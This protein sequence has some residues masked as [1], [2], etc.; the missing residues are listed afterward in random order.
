VEELGFVGA[1]FLI[2]V[3]LFLIVKAITITKEA[4][5]AEGRILATGIA[6][7]IAIQSLF[8]IASNVAL[9][10]LTG[11]PLPFISH[12]G[13]SLIVTMASIGI[14]INIKRTQ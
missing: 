4:A 1:L 10:P 12:G 6:G 7:L 13:S 3:F 9:V 5:N 14:L 8:N 11:I 2:S